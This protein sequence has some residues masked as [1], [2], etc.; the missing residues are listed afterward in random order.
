[1]SW[2]TGWSYRKALT[3]APSAD[4]AQTAYQMK[5]LVGESSGASGSQ[6]HCAGHVLSSFNDLRFTTSDGEILCDY[7]I[8]S[9]TGATPNQLATVWIKIPSIAAHPANTTIYMYYG[10]AG[11]SAVSSGAN[12][13]VVFDDFERG[14]DGDSIGGGWTEHPHVH[15]STDHDIGDV[16][17]YTG[18]RSARWIGAADAPYALIPGATAG[19]N[20]A[21]RFRYYKET[22]TRLWLQHSDGANK[23]STH[24]ETSEAVTVYNGASYVDTTLDCLADSW[25]LVEFNAFD[26]AGLTASIVIDGATKTGIDISY[27]SGS[28]A[29]AVYIQGYTG[30]NLWIDDLIVR[31]WT[32][33]EPVWGSCGSEELSPSAYHIILSAIYS[34]ETPEVNRAFV[35]GSDAAGGQVSGSAVTQAD[36]D[37]VGERMDA[38]HNPAVSSGEVA[39]AVA[40]A[41]LAKCRLDGRRAELVI[42]PHCGLELWDVLAVIDTVANQNTLYRVT[43][44]QLEYDTVKGVFL[45][46]L[47]LSAP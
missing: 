19:A 24:F 5:L 44:Y 31:N 36:V 7:W 10:N 11:A 26:W 34:E 40:A 12:T 25:G 46:H 8:E 6:V 30:G 43:G 29:N 20:T 41:M 27:A 22:A 47:Q 23:L 28:N 1:M 38:H 39:A 4:G 17:G 37:L 15:I 35:V 16:A 3:I 42:P 13:F 18:T 45:H 2:L 32:A 9:I 21:I 14:S 33:N